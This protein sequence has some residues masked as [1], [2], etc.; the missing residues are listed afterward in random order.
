MNTPNRM[1]AVDRKQSILDGAVKL[2]QRQHYATI[3]R[4]QLASACDVAG[5]L[6]NHYFGTIEKLRDEIVKEAVRREVLRVVAQGIIAKHPATRRASLDLRR[7]AL[8][9]LTR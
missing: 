8:A 4:D 9:S 7:R 1:A 2:A 5:A 3:T 6:I